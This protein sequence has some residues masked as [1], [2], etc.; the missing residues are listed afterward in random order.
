MSRL[1]FI[2]LPVA[3]V[4]KA[5]AFYKALGFGHNP[6][7]SDDTASC[8]VISDVIHVML[9]THEKFTSLTPKAICDT[10]TTTQM[11]LA[12]NCESREEVD[13]FVAKALSAGGTT[14]GKP[15]DDE[16]MYQHDFTDLDGHGWGLFHMK[17][18]PQ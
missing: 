15:E 3:D 14:Q 2:T 7:F 11:L 12:L 10:K 6:Q 5:T 4:P 16:F 13:G 1:I 8:I 9:G 17:A 18:T